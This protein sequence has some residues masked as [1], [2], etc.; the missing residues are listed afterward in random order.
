MKSLVECC[1]HKHL[2]AWHTAWSESLFDSIPWN[3]SKPMNVQ[4]RKFDFEAWLVIVTVNF[5][6][7]NITAFTFVEIRWYHK[8]AMPLHTSVTYSI[9]ERERERKT[10]RVKE[11][12]CRNDALALG[13]KFPAL[14]L[15]CTT[16][17]SLI[18]ILSSA[19]I[20]NF[21]STE[22]LVICELWIP[23]VRACHCRVSYH[24]LLTIYQ[25]HVCMCKA[26]SISTEP[27]QFNHG[28]NVIG[29]RNAFRSVVAHRPRC[30]NKE[31]NQFISILTS[32]YTERIDWGENCQ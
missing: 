13:F 12:E 29:F 9:W 19:Q 24:P 21:R 23:F 6:Y 11:N 20:M 2:F 8:Q 17:L 31:H 15:A 32:N 26:F 14:S 30:E 7:S 22:T 1:K 25:I 3:K 28:G 27:K 5:V 4:K 18:I 10:D 16:K